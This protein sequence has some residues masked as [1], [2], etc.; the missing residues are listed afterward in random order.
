MCYSRFQGYEN[1][2]SLRIENFL[3]LLRFSLMNRNPFIAAVDFSMSTPYLYF[4]SVIEQ[5]D[6]V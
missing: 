2:E 5:S 4:C 1:I 6:M 3:L